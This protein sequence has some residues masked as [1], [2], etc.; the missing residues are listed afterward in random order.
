M[1]V[2]VQ[3]LLSVLFFVLFLINSYVKF[4][5]NRKFGVKRMNEFGSS[6]VFIRSFASRSG[7]SR[8][9]LFV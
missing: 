7:V 3:F 6:F 9:D 8:N 1:K 5:L 4:N 2:Q